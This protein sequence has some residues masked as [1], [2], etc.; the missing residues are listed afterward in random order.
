[1]R[2]AR[3]MVG[4]AMLISA[5]AG[6]RGAVLMADYRA[7]PAHAVAE[8]SLAGA[9]PETA[10]EQFGWAEPVEP[11]PVEP[12]PVEAAPAA[13]PPAPVA[14][15]EPRYFAY[16]QAPE[17]PRGRA[18]YGWGAGGERAGAV[19]PV[20]ERVAFLTM[21][22]DAARPP[23]V[24]PAAGGA[25]PPP[26][27][28]PPDMAAQAW[29]EAASGYAR[30]NSGDREGAADALRLALSLAPDHP[31]A[32]IWRQDLRRITRRWRFEV[33]SLSRPV[34]D[35]AL[36]AASQVLGSSATLGF[37][38]WS[39]NPTGRRPVELFARVIANDPTRTYKRNG[40][41]QG[42]AGVNW[43]PFPGVPV[44]VSAE[45]LF[46]INRPARDDWS[47][48]ASG[49]LARRVKGIDLDSFAEAGVVGTRPDW[50]FGG[51]AAATR[52]FSLPAR[53]FTAAGVGVWGSVQS[54]P[55]ITLSRVDVGPTL[56][57][58]RGSF[59][60]SVSADYRF[61]LQGNAFPGDGPAV[62]VSATF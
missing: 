60:V 15:P 19:A 18:G 13:A 36:P 7:S 30:L 56:R 52:A 17:R 45:R 50:F 55:T 32:R 34:A 23:S 47:I 37:L 44:T 26:E 11:V 22:G 54:T 5:W 20:P 40:G 51:Q 49:G 61:R 59:P 4:A 25:A 46:A 28:T 39:P 35:P 58:R 53:F 29:R 33:Y 14:G 21:P 16:A 2:A 8:G 1:M 43:Q 31:N 12:A 38:G 62:T 42:A 41:I 6:W 9:Q 57:V 48:R 24:P 27:R 3:A 10:E